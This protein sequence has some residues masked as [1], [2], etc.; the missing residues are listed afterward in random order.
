MKIMNLG[1][2]ELKMR[3]QITGR[4]ETETSVLQPQENKF[5]QQPNDLRPGFFPGDSNEEYSLADTL[6]L[7]L[8]NLEWKI[9]LSP[10]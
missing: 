2:L 9:K 7:A 3:T 1:C 5:Y 10:P 6:I 4:K 8:Q